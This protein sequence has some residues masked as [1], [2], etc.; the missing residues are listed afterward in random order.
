MS[1][2]ADQVPPKAKECFVV[3]PIGANGTDTRKRSNQIFRHVISPVVEGLG[4]GVTRADTIEQSGQITTQIIEKIIGVDLVIADLTDQNPNVFY[5]L[6]IRH[7]FGKPFV[8]LVAA[9][10]VIPFDIQGL[11]AIF[12]DHQDLD[13]VHEAKSQLRGAIQSIEGGA[14]VETPVTHTID[15]QQLRQSGSSEARGIADIMEEVQVLKRVV[16]HSPRTRQPNA[17]LVALRR[18]VEELRKAGRLTHQDREFLISPETT[19]GHDRWVEKL[20]SDLDPWGSA[21]QAPRS[22]SDEPPF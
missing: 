11:R 17:N 3:S 6:A 19:E 12:L 10:Q 18:F 8:H 16:M 9:G 13:S 22:F 5:E 7:A 1:E 14:P 15:V 4:Y 20:I 21:P 2:E